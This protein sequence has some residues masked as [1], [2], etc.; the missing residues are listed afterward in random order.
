MA[1]DTVLDLAYIK[2]VITGMMAKDWLYKSKVYQSGLLGL[3]GFPANALTAK[4]ILHK[5]FQ[6]VDSQSIKAGQTLTLGNA[7]SQAVVSPIVIQ[8]AA[9]EEPELAG[10]VG[11]LSVQERDMAFTEGANIKA[12]NIIDDEII[13]MI[14]GVSATLSAT[15]TDTAN[16]GSTA[17]VSDMIAAMYKLG[18]NADALIGGGIIMRSLVAQHLNVLGA[19]AMTANVWGNEAQ[20][21]MIKNG[22]LP[23]NI[24]G[25]TPIVTNKLS[26]SSGSKPYTYLVA[27]KSVL[28]GYQGQPDFDV[29][30]KYGAFKTK[31]YIMQVK[32]KIGIPLM[33]WTLAAKEDIS[34]TEL[35]TSTSW[36]F[37]GT[38]A[39][40]VAIVRVETA[41]A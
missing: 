19:A 16:N 6:D 37:K 15:N 31:A 7:S 23:V 11:A 21:N 27:Q 34:N 14:E 25:M 9:I 41:A 35:A 32:T 39:K 33:S 2:E 26:L 28:L 24:L 30:A 1:Y 8:Y 4:D 20:N 38:D 22:G 5:T 29:N 18:D 13:S 17:E 10:E 40:N 3:V 36:E 12:A